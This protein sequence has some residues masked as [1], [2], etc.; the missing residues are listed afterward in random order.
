MHSA[1]A[2]T[3]IGCYGLTVGFVG[4]SSSAG[5]SPLEAKDG[6]FTF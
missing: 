6:T 2:G 1:D 4:L 3:W 5:T